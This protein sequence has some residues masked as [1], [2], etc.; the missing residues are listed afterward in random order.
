M[1]IHGASNFYLLLFATVALLAL[2]AVA[3]AEDAAQAPTPAASATNGPTPAQEPVPA[4]AKDSSAALA[5][6]A[7]SALDHKDYAAARV[8]IGR[9]QSLYGAQAAEMQGKLTALPDKDHALQQW[10]LNDVGTCTFILGKVAEAEGKKDE[11]MAAYKM[12]VEKYSYSQCWDKQG[13]FWQPAVAAKERIA[14]IS[15]DAE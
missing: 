2:P 15:L 4:M 14:F 3:S 7:W 8:A 13:W 5:S 12:V 6:E 11:A 9:C 1:R 10:A